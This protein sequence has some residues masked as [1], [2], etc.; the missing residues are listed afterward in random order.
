M[1]VSVIISICDNREE[2]FLRSLDTWIKQTFSN[3]DFEIIIVDDANRIELHKLCSDYN[4]LYKLNFQIIRINND[5]CKIPITTFTPALSNNI[6]FKVS[7]GEVVYITGPETLQYEKNIEIAYSFVNRQECGYGLV[8]KSNISFVETIAKNWDVY[9]KIPFKNLFQIPG[10]AAQCLTKFPH[11]PRYHYILTVKKSYVE[12]IGGYDERF[13]QGFCAEDDDFG[14]RMEMNGIQ[15]LFE[16]KM[17]GIH[18]DHSIID[19]KSKKHSLRKSQDGQILRQKN[20]KLMKENLLKKQIVVN[21][22]HIWGDTNI[23][24]EHKVLKG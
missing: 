3:K 15:P 7:N 16:H 4:K 9:K 8:Y 12:N 23:I 13:C 5:L 2:F 24:I 22:N 11:P 17:L 14:N 21:K 18:Q 10:A 19:A 20:I 1:K 6:G